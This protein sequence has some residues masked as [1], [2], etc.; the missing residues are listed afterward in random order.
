MKNIIC[1]YLFATLIFIGVYTPAAIAQ[2]KWEYTLAPLYLWATGI[3]GQ[4][5]IGPV[6]APLDITFEDVLDNL[7]SI[8]TIHFETSKGN[9]GILADI[10]QIGLAPQST[11]PN[12]APIATDITNNIYELAAIYRP[13]PDGVWEFLGGVRVTEFEID[14]AIG[15]SPKMKLA[16]ESWLDGYVGIRAT[17]GLSEKASFSFRGDI[18]TGDSDLVWNVLAKF[19]YRFA[20][21]FSALAGYRWLDYDY[22]TGSGASRFTYDVTYQGPVLAAVFNW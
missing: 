2:D 21:N 18:G 16:D 13:D 8:F 12:G 5:Q 7:E 15:P 22:E 19:D 6:T 3:E 20:K 4:S 14:A 10:T 11:L 9:W 17:A 1:K